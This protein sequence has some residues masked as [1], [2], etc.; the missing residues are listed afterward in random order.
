MRKHPRVK[1]PI[2]GKSMT[3]QSFRDECNINKIME[4]FQKT[5]AI[6]HYAKYGGEYGE[7]P[8]AA[9]LD[10]MNIVAQAE[11]MFAD[12]PSSIRK[13]FSN[14]PAE[15]LEFMEDPKNRQEALKLNL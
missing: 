5:G 12:L 4:K 2:T 7:V 14:D 1:S 8:Q 15:F 13:R 3:K 10:A 11:E 9:L 6:D